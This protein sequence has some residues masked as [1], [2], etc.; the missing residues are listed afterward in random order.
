MMAVV[1][2]LWREPISCG[3]ARRD[4][5]LKSGETKHPRLEPVRQTRMGSQKKFAKEGWQEV[6]Q[7]API[8]KDRS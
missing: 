5:A 1:E 6:S 2:R 8:I 4:L 7:F 3:G